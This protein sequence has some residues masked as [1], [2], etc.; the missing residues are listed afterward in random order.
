MIK[1][2]IHTICNTC[3]F[4]YLLI[5]KILY[6]S[7]PSA[8]VTSKCSYVLVSHRLYQADPDPLQ[9]ASRLASWDSQGCGGNSV[10]ATGCAHVAGVRTCCLI[11]LPSYSSSPVVCVP[12]RQHVQCIYISTSTCTKTSRLTSSLGR[13]IRERCPVCPLLILSLT[14]V[15]ERKDNMINVDMMVWTQ[16]QSGF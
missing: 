11:S 6:M 16:R 14:V 9:L 15:K 12:R 10:I 1:I 8:P 4:E 2:L 7:S 3:I 13:E 5:L